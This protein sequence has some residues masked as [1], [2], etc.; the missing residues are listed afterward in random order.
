MSE[1]KQQYSR[2]RSVAPEYVGVYLRVG[3]LYDGD[4]GSLESQKETYRD[5]IERRP[6]WKCVDFYSDPV[7]PAGKAETRMELRRLVTDCRAGKIT[8]IVTRSIGT[9]SVNAEELSGL[10]RALNSLP[11]PVG[12]YFEEEQMDTLGQEAIF[13]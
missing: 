4:D 2:Q 7:P 9:L 3:D 8:H 13:A 6:G 11:M 5:W 1:L 10:F 12:V